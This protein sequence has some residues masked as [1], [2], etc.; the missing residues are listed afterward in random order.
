MWL[1]EGSIIFRAVISNPS[2]IISQTAPL[3]FYLPKELKDQ[4]II[5]MDPDLSSTYD[6]DQETLVVTGNFDLSPGAT[7][8]V[9]V[10]VEDVWQLK[11][12]ELIALKNKS[13]ELLKTLNKSNLYSQ[14][15]V[16][17]SGISMT[18]DKLLHSQNQNVQPQNRIRAYREAQLAL[19]TTQ[20]NITELEN[21]VAQA[22]SNQSIIGF[23]GGVSTTAVFGIVLVIVAGFIFLSIYFKKLGLTPKSTSTEVSDSTES[24]DSTDLLNNRSTELPISPE[25][26]YTSK[27]T[28]LTYNLSPKPSPSW[29]MPAIIA[30][31]MVVTAGGTLL[32]T[33]AAK[34]KPTAVIN[35]I[36]EATPQPKADPP[37]ADT[38]SPSPT[39]TPRSEAETPSVVKDEVGQFTFTLTVPED[40]SVNIRNKPSSDADIIMAI[41]ETQD[42]Y[43]FKEDGDW[44]QIGFKESD[45]T[46]GYW[47]NVLFITEK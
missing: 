19:L 43:V 22:G 24:T 16:L 40:S 11:E 15:I 38:P 39:P 1:E 46:K 47:V 10:E 23:V 18:I 41:K 42:I 13:S 34:P 44:R 4:D 5:S 26:D 7:K 2:T 32:L 27:L 28:P 35:Q 12:D 14:G 33:Q 17:D 3:K 25:A 30:V 45:S 20:G 21:L 9:A 6:T 8:I 37:R 31:V 36:I 29:Q